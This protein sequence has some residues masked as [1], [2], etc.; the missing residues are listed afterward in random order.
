MESKD[1]KLINNTI[2]WIAFIPSAAL[3]AYLTYPLV[4]RIVEWVNYKLS[5]DP[6][7]DILLKQI[8]DDLFSSAI[9]GTAFICVGCFVAPDRKKDITI[10][11]SVL[12][13]MYSMILAFITSDLSIP[14][15][16]GL[17]IGSGFATW[18]IIKS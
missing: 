10:V 2:R 1:T 12:L 8:A 5:Y 4:K 13:L 9:C 18:K 17:N 16:I 3:V 6:D 15:L 11:L 14:I 7:R